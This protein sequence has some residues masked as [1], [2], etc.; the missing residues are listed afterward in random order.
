[1]RYQWDIKQIAGHGAGAMRAVARA[2]QAKGPALAGPS[3]SN[4]AWDAA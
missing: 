4:T 2:W 1:M 3:F